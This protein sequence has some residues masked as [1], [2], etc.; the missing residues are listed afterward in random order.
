MRWTPGINHS[1][2]TSREFQDHLDASYKRNE[3]GNRDGKRQDLNGRRSSGKLGIKKDN[4][5]KDDALS[6]D[7]VTRYRTIA[8]RANF[9]A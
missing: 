8:A 2:H 7:E 9:L 3:K 5:D 1:W 4:D 6:A